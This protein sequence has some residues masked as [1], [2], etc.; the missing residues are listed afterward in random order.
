DET[1]IANLV[2]WPN[3]FER[4]RAIVMGAR[5]MLVRGRVQQA[6]NVTHIVAEQ[7]IDRTEDLSLLSENAPGDPLRQAL[8][9]ADEV[10]RPVPGREGPTSRSLHT[11]PRNVRF[12]PKSRDFH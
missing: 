9:R 5:I 2:I 7:L 8:D 4:F 10:A 1:G 3:V 11:H 12:V 6:D